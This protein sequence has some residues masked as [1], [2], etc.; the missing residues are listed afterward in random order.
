MKK[1]IFA[2]ILLFAI[3]TTAGCSKKDINITAE[4]ITANTML[5]KRN[6]KL[7]VAI[8]E[9]FDKEYYKLSELEEFVKKEITAYNQVAGSEEVTIEELSL[10][11]GKA[12]MMLGY[13][14]MAHY[15]A[16]NKVAAAYFSADTKNVALE[17]PDQYVSAKNE[18]KVDRASAFKDGKSRV[19]VVYEPYDIIVD[20]KVRYYSENATIDT[21]DVIHS[22]EDG[23]TVVIYEPSK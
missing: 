2:A 9:E 11:N 5:V 12:V 14:G 17:L 16:F 20:G 19:L 18:K 15:S 23:I 1:Y 13:T 8:L 3:L 6:G 7:Q 22:S 4:D 10:K 21:D